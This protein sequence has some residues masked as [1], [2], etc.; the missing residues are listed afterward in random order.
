MHNDINKSSKILLLYILVFIGFLIFLATMFYTAIKQRE[1][2]SRFTSERTNAER[3]SIISADGFHL[4]MTKKVY[5]AMINTR[6]LDPDKKELFIKLFSIYSDIPV[7]KIRNKLRKHGYIILTYNLSELHAQYLKSLAYELR[8]LKVFIPY[9]TGSGRLILQGL[10]IQESGE[11]RIYPYGDLLTPVIGYPQKYEKNNYTRSK[12]KKG[13]ERQYNEELTPQKDGLQRAPRDV[14]GYMILNKESKTTYPENGLDVKLTIPV[15]LQSRVEKMCDKMKAKM[16]ARQIMVSVMDAESGKML[17]LATSNRFKPKDIKRDQI[18]SLQVHAVEYSFEPGSVLKPI[19]FALLMRNKKVNPFEVV[20]VHNGRFRIGKRWITDEHK[21]HYLSAENV[22]VYSS[23]IG[24]AI[25]AQRLNSSQF[26]QGLI[27][28]GF[29]VPSGIDLTSEK[30]GRIPSRRQLGTETYK[31]SASY[32]YAISANLIQLIKA[33]NVFNNHGRM[34]TPILTEALITQD[35][36][37]IPVE[38]EDPV[39]VISPEIAERIKRILVKTAVEGTGKKAL[40]DGIT[41]GGKT[42]TAQI[43]EK[44]HY[45]RKYNT[46]FIGFADDETHNYTIGVTVVRPKTAFKFAAQSAAPVFKKTVELMIEEG[47][48]IPSAK[49]QHKKV[50]KR[51]HH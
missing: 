45:R 43:A 9:K 17:V 22:I 3:G 14:N 10:D 50:K 34:L 42:G 26:Y 39:Q 40:V 8:R 12:G 25:L 21:E 28:F 27:D 41:V 35:D 7:Q 48:L 51:K 49:L 13:I 29:S 20:N 46:S 23:N 18:S 4:A 33:Y 15:T 5:K 44:G 11:A 30:R 6:N 37:I 36:E 24:I 31:G 47:Y 1:L 32:G 19:T 16:G 2:P 38:S